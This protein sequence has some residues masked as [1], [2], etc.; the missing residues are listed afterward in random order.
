MNP[1][2][3]SSIERAIS[4]GELELEPEL[5]EHVGRPGGGRDR[6]VAVLGDSGARSRRDERS[7]GRD[8]E[9]PATVAAGTC[10]VDEV[11]ARG[12]H[13]DHVVAH[14]LG[15]PGDLVRRLAFQAQGDEE[16]TDLGRRRAPGH[17][18]VHHLPRLFTRQVFSVEQLCQR[19]SI[20]GRH[21]R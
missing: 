14:R 13:R 18:R 21:R 10:R 2:P 5:L 19:R 1:K 3:S 4:G 17:D 7:S 15:G 11:V 12:A 9:R 6:A 8:V 20:I 16:P